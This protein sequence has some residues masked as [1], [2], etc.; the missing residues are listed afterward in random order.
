MVAGLRRA[1]RRA[2]TGAAAL[3]LALA[4]PAAGQGEATTAG[5]VV[6]RAL[7]RLS[8]E[9]RDIELPTSSSALFDRMAI[10]HA[11]CRHPAGNPSGDAYALLR[12]RDVASG[13]VLFQG[14]MIASAPSLSALD[15]PRYDV[16]VLRCTTS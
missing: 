11:E 7:D 16:W 5:G 15:H 8:G 10:D 9:T 3:A 6:I 12:V 2:G 13:D 4:G 1:A 14:W